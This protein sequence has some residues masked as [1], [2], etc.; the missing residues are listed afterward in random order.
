M[1]ENRVLRRIFG[2]ND[3]RRIHN[4]ELYG[5]YSSLNIIWVIKLK[6]MRQEVHVSHVGGSDGV[7]KILVGRP[8]GKR[9]LRRPRRRWVANVTTDVQDDLA[10][11]IDRWWAVMNAVMDLRV[12][13]NVGSLTVSERVSFSRRILILGVSKLE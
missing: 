8:Y 12:P 2:S 5:L 10:Q 13:N 4:E 6:G 1:F 7:Y 11:D 9:P 3:C